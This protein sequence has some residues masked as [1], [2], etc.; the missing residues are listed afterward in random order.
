[1]QDV[2]G[3]N[4]A[5]VVALF[6]LASFV[7]AGL[8]FLV[9]PMVAKMVLPLYGGSPAVWNTSVLFFQAVLLAGYG[10]SHLSTRRLGLRLQPRVHL[11]TLVAPLAVLPIALPSWA[12]PRAGTP[13]ALWLLGVL[14][15]AVGLPFLVVST[16]GPLLQ[17]WF[18]VTGHPRARDPYFLYAAGNAG[19]LLALLGYPLVVE[20]ALSLG[21]QAR[22]WTGGYVVF[23]VLIAACAL[24]LSRR[25][26]APTRAPAP[27]PTDAAPPSER[28]AWPR[29]ARWVLL[30]FVPSS[31]MLGVTT[32][33]STDLAAVPLLWVVPLSLYLVTFIVAFGRPPAHDAAPGSRVAAGLVLALVIVMTE[34]LVPVTAVAV[35]LHLAAFTAIALVAHRRLAA[36]RPGPEQLTEF[37]LLVSVGGVLGGAFNS[38][39]A[40]TVFDR[41]LEYPL[42]VAAALVLTVARGVPTVLTRRYGRMGSVVWGL[43]PVGLVVIVTRAARDTA[44]AGRVLPAVAVLAAA[45]AAGW[46]AARRPVPF[47]VGVVGLLAVTEGPPPS[48]VVTDRTF[49]GVYRV[50][51]ADGRRFFMHGVTAHGSQRLGAAR[52]AEPE[53]YYTRSGPAGAV[54]ETLSPQPL[55]DEVAIVGLGTGALAAYGR[56]GQTITYYEIDPAVVDVAED[57]RHFTFLADSRAR[58]EVEVGDGRLRLQEAPPDRFGLMVFDAFSSAAIPVHLLTDD[59]VSLYR[60][61]LRPGGVLL[62]HVSNR[63]LD[64]GPVLAATAARQ[65]LAGL[66]RTDHALDEATGHLPSRWALLAEDPAALDP[67]RADTRWAPL[68][69]RQVLWTDDFSNVVTVLGW[70]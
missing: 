36:D 44:L 33:I 11:A 6:A 10:Y 49:F 39:V 3:L 70:R 67:W 29:R 69:D 35:A 57:P 24:Q 14:G 9:Q 55:A 53:T 7:G 68:G 51:E 23:A 52:P 48:N 26:S 59:A 13:T 2:D 62:F 47:V 63:H 1:M 41:V 56:P 32:Y 38:L 40:P 37:Y 15:V 18:S 30:A 58:V 20:R 46:L 27:G 17:R 45:V 28:V 34:Q 8:L 5:A 54:L 22:L 42:V 12:P 65:G 25:T 61:K 19:S 60:R 21:Q 31:L 66:Q 50:Y 43:A 4:V 64:L 16:T